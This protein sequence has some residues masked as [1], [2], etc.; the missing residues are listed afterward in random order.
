MRNDIKTNTGSIRCFQSIYLKDIK[1]IMMKDIEK[2]CDQHKCILWP[3][4]M[5]HDNLTQR[6]K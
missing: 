1:L 4:Y 6:K 3:D 5:H 2:K